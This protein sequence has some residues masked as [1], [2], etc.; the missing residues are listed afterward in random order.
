ML[1]LH[2]ILTTKSNN[3]SHVNRN[4]VFYDTETTGTN[5]E[6]DQI[7]QFAAILT[8]ANFKELDRLNVR[9]RRLPWIIPSPSAMIITGTS[10]HQIDNSD[11]PQF[12][13]MMAD[14]Q[15]KLRSWSPALFI[16]YNSYKF[17]EPLL[18]RALWQ[19]LKPPYLTVTYGNARADVLPLARATSK[20]TPHALAVPNLAS[21]RPV[22]RLDRLAPLNGYAHHDAHDALGDV[23][24]V[25]HICRKI[26]SRSD[27]L[28]TAFLD[29]PDVE[30]V[31]Q[32]VSREEPIFV[33][34]P[35][36]DYRPGWWGLPI[37]SD[38]KRKSTR[39]V[40]KLEADWQ[41]FFSNTISAQ[42]TLITT[43]TFQLRRAK[44]NM[45]PIA[46]SQSDAAEFF[47]IVPSKRVTEEAEFLASPSR[48]TSLMKLAAK[49]RAE[50]PEPRAL[51]QR[52]FE[53][54][55]SRHDEMVMREFGA[56]P[57]SQRASL[58]RKF[59]DPRFQQIA[60][61]LIFLMA[62]ESLS[63]GDRFRV[64]RGIRDRLLDPHTD[65]TL[66][67]T[68][69]LARSELDEIRNKPSSSIATQEIED[70]LIEIENSWS[71][72]DT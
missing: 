39:L 14:V 45:F 5:I 40:A 30:F 47:G 70:W 44:Q 34:E 50:W 22:F 4:L 9:C 13:D 28:W 21:G 63:K 18:Q 42:E 60:Q 32:L 12:P 65:K 46:F 26:A 6:F 17:D 10:P 27:A 38:N 66:W 49:M 57:W 59:D 48:R 52:I 68:I 2:H 71:W 43:S 15:E 53:A 8:D 37:G 19:A 58:I 33:A 62:P 69:A 72:R 7:L 31:S 3:L 20:I 55:S 67:R 56:L 54:F 36:K 1:S 41:S 51:E 24:A 35:T 64:E 11:L 16:G 61:R 23:L 25:I 29:C